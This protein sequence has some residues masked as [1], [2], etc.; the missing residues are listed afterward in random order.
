[1]TV[2][3]RADSA[4][5]Q[6]CL[7]LDA[8]DDPLR[9]ERLVA[10]LEQV[11]GGIPELRSADVMVRRASEPA[12]GVQRQGAK[13]V[14]EIGAMLLLLGPVYAGP[15]AEVLCTAIRGWAERDRRVVI[16]ARN[17]DR[18]VEITGNPRRRHEALV[19]DVLQL[20]QDDER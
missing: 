8:G 3:G 13:G 4:T 5:P 14:A 20:G 18:E 9:N 7:M 15:V 10:D 1:M 16:R 6:L 12:T 2:D 19:H 17:G 11:L